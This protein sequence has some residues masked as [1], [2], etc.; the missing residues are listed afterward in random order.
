MADQVEHEQESLHFCQIGDLFFTRCLSTKIKSVYYCIGF[1]DAT[2]C[3]LG[4][5]SLWTCVV[6]HSTRSGRSLGMEY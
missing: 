6:C 2:E 5:I 4:Y 3:D 1:V